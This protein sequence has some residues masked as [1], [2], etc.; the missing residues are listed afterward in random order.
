[1]KRKI[2]AP[3]RNQTLFSHPLAY[4]YY[5][6]CLIVLSCSQVLFWHSHRKYDGRRKNVVYK[7]TV[8]DSKFTKFLEKTGSEVGHWFQMLGIESIGYG[9]GFSK[10]EAF[11]TGW[12]STLQGKTYLMNTSHTHYCWGKVYCSSSKALIQP[13]V[14]NVIV[15]FAVSHKM[16]LLKWNITNLINWIVTYLR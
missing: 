2:S 9:D 1:M 10:T 5:L 13:E 11:L 12:V 15:N 4:H 6:S 8:F 14:W 7:Y 16:Y 3:A